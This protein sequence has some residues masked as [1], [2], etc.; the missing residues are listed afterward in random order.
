[1]ERSEEIFNILNKVDRIMQAQGITFG[2]VIHLIKRDYL[3]NIEFADAT[4]E[5]VA[6]VLN[7]YI[8]EHGL[9]ESFQYDNA[10]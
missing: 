1:M 2:A 4:N 3:P 6:K 8:S 10:K 5:A 9:Q 7:Q